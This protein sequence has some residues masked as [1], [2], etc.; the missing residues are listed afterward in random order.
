VASRFN[1]SGEVCELLLEVSINI[2]E[3]LQL[4]LCIK[5]PKATRGFEPVSYRGVL[6]SILLHATVYMFLHNLLNI[7]VQIANKIELQKNI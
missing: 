2:P 5:I 1:Q 6:L 4:T 7:L 3:M